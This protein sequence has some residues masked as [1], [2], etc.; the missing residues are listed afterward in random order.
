MWAPYGR[1]LDEDVFPEFGMAG[2]QLWVRFSAIVSTLTSCDGDLD[3]LDRAL[4][5]RART[6]AP[7]MATRLSSP[8]AGA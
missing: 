4:V 5:A 6:V 3:D 1:L 2:Q 8:Q 7:P